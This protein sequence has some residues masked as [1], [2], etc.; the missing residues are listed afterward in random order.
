MSGTHAH[1]AINT[2]HN[3]HLCNVKITQ[4]DYNT[5]T[6]R[7]IFKRKHPLRQLD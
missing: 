7:Q 5:S 6:L 1:K 4:K 2:L 3:T